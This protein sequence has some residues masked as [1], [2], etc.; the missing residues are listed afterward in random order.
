MKEYF[1]HDHNARKDRKVIVLV[2]KYKAAGY[3]I[4]WATNEM[5]HEEGGELEL[6][7][8]T[9]SAI[10]KHLN[11]DIV[12]IEAVIK[13]CINE[14]KLYFLSEGKLTSK[15][16]KQNLTDR[17]DKKKAKSEQAALAG[18]LG[19]IKSGE[20]RRTKQNEAFASSERSN[21]A[22]VNES[23]VNESKEIKESN[24]PV[25]ILKNSN[26][27]RQPNIP[28]FDEV[29]RVFVS[30]GGT[31]EMA[32]TFFNVNNGLGWFKNGSP[33]TNFSNLVP[34]YVENWKKNLNNSK[35]GKKELS[36]YEKVIL[37]NREKAKSFDYDK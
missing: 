6:D 19:G 10:S 31:E 16:V 29:H 13:D 32:K 34:S 27:F 1:S 2:N 20:S 23:K 3:G 35:N 4:F 9:Y 5:M 18:R 33:I 26:L 8:M 22:K 28:L 21:E 12:L 15:R 7:E 11:E 14:F 24:T 17:E 36:E 25:S 37:K 30:N